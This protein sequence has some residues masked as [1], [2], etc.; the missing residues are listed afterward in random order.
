MRRGDIVLAAFKGD[1]GKPR[2]F[3]VAQADLIG[4]H[5]Y[6]SVVV[7]PLTSE[8]TGGAVCRVLVEATPET[9]LRER[10]EIMVEKLAAPPRGRLRDVI[11]RVDDAT[12]REV[13]RALLL[14]LG[15]GTR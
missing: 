8:L 6:T 5:G 15:I 10:S 14:A 9:G 11:G 4:A 3:L 7:C 12:M 1:W 2:P 13:E